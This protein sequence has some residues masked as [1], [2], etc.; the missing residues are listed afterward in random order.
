MI[1]CTGWMQ[2]S[3]VFMDVNADSLF[4][5]ANRLYQQGEYEPALELYNSIILSGEE[6]ADLYYNMGNA[7]YRSN[8]IGHAILY[9]NKALKLE[10]SHEDALHNL[11]YV[12]RY[13]LDVFEEVPVLFL[14]TW[15]SGFLQIFPERTWSIMA[16]VFFILILSGL[17]IYLF[18]RHMA[19]KKAGFTSGLIAFLLFIVTFSCAVSR[20]R[21][22]VNPDEGI[23]LVPSVVVRSSPSESGTELFILHEGTKIKVNEEVS[24]WQ[25]VRVI[26]GREG[27]IR[28]S[29][30]ETI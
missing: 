14:A 3:T 18:S 21:E 12:S 2:A 13:R 26:D 30:F 25:N 7:A 10:P 5:E 15:I 9:Y 1:I 16:L 4:Q 8:S 11:E 19:I 20:H 27:W 24:G 28:T 29:D 22:I 23:I 6:S 17:L